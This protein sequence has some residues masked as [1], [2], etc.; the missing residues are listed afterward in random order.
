MFSADRSGSL[1]RRTLWRVAVRIGIVVAIATVVSFWHVRSGLESQALEKLVRFVEERRARESHVF[2]MAGEHLEIIEKA[3]LERLA[4]IEALDPRPR[5]DVLFETRADGTLRLRERVFTDSGVSGFVGKHV[6]VSDD[7]RRRLLA[8]YDV[9]RQF[10]PGWQRRYVNLYV[11]TPES[12]VLMFWPDQPWALESNDWQIH[13]KLAL[14]AGLQDEVLVVG[15]D[16]A[17][18]GSE[19]RWSDLY[20]DYGVND[21]MVSATRPIEH[22]GQPMLT[23]GQDVL[24]SELFARTLNSESDGTYTMIF[25][26]DGRL[27]AHPRFTEALQAQSGALLIQEAGDPQLIRT[28]ELAKAR[29]PGEVVVENAEDGEFLAVTR[30]MGPGWFLVTG[31]SKAVVA[32]RAFETARLI[33]LLGAVALVVE[34][35]ILFWVL[36]NQ[37]ALPLRGL[38]RATRRIASGHFD[39]KLSVERNDELGQLARSFNAMAQEI[40]NREATLAERSAKLG[41]LNEQLAHELAERERMEEQVARQRDALHQSEK[42][43]ALGSL[44]AGVAHELNNPLSVVVGRTMMLEERFRGTAQADMIAKI[45]AAAERCAKIVKTF[46]AMARQEQPSRQA[47]CI[48]DV[49]RS[50]L[51]IVGYGLR[52]EA[53]ELE[54]DV[55]AGLPEISADPNQLAQ[56]FTNLLVNAQQALASHPQPRIVRISGSLEEDDKELLIRVADNGPGIPSDVVSRIFE[57]FYTTKPVG[58]GT[59]LGL[60]V[61]RGL[62]EAHGGSI[63]VHLPAKGGTEFRIRLP[64]DPAARAAPAGPARRMDRIGGHHILVVEDEPEIARM[65]AEV[66]EALGHRVEIAESGRVALNRLTEVEFDL[67]VSDLRMP[68]IDGTHLFHELKLRHPHQAS[69][70]VFVTGDSLSGAADRF[71]AEAERPVI[72]K[73]FTPEEV[74]RVVA[75]Q[76]ERR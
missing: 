12:A 25:R 41:E 40:E 47:T 26:E 58:E 38:L 14:A 8:A 11:V 16:N 56:V 72:E 1:T 28:F 62:I 35:A 29:Q 33:L 69:R 48:S 22:D 49:V 23:V 32:E 53:I 30:L 15:A 66:L 75:E 67:V 57:P 45:R 61:C 44:L 17:A 27:I 24:L 36:R 73:P 50:T 71:L 68:D 63:D 7:L 76:L 3:Y 55:E 51:D 70:M 2:V 46:V 13:G 20:F 39:A 18:T 59:G 74:R 65:L 42:L 4:S 10:G 6:E 37:V 5:F 52:R 34:I 60:S 54:L 64:V 31:F 21:W 19:E 43:N 9:L